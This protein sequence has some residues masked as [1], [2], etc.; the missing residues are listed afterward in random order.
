[1]NITV[2]G[3]AHTL[4]SPVNITGFLDARGYGGMLVA[5]AVNSV[6]VPRGEYDE[7]IIAASDEVE[8]VAP[9]QGG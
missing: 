8:I 4:E 3:D 9:M 6:F 2:N 5:V 1:M 7:R